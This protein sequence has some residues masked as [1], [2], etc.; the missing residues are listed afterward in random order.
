MNNQQFLQTI[1]RSF[2][3]FLVA[4]SRSPKKLKVLHKEIA[5]DIQNRLGND[6]TVRSYG[7]GDGTEGTIR[8]RYMEKRVDILIYNNNKEL[9]AVGIKF[10]MNN[11]SQN[12][13]NYFENMLGETAN[14]RASNKNYFQILI[15]PDRV[16][17]YNKNGKINRWEEVSGHN[18]DKYIALSND[19]EKVYMH[20]P[21]KTLLFVMKFPPCNNNISTRSKYNKFYLGLPIIEIKT[22]D[23]VAGNFEKAVILNDYDNFIEKVV[24]N[25]KSI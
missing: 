1:S 3:V 21:I 7:I 8:G 25:I 16:P 6:Y 5:V 13:N 23:N 15:L 10:V 9:G 19:D 11:Y 14:I 20:T 12:S 24:H 2:K 18:I 4:G 17:Y 22:S